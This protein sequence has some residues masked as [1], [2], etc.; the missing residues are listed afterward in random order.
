MVVEKLI[1]ECRGLQN[2]IV[3]F[4]RDFHMNPELAYEE[5]RTSSIVER[6]L[7]NLGYSVTR[8]AG[9]GVIGVIGSGGKTVALR[10]DM[11]ALPINEE[12]D[13]PYKSRV[14][15]KMHACGHD[16]HTAMLL[17]AA[18]VIAKFKDKFR[19]RVKLI[20]QPAEEGGAG[21]K[22]IVEEGHL[23]DVDAI[24]GLHVW[25]ELPSGVI[26]VRKGPF[27]ASADAFRITI[28]GRGGHAAA[29]HYAVDPIACAIDLASMYQKIITREIDPLE[30]AVISLTCIKAGTTFNVIPEE[31]VMLG[32]IRAFRE[33]VRNYIVERMKEITSKG[34]AVMR[35]EG[36]FELTKEY[37]PP[38][39]NNEELAEMAAREL[40]VLG[41][42]VEPKQSMGAEDFSFYTRKTKGLYVVLGIRNEE[43][44][45]I[46]P[47]HH[48]K[49][50]VDE[51]VLWM[52]AA[53]YSILA[54]KFLEK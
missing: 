35:C 19:G 43:K 40:K 8:A 54:Y 6:E 9:T 4:R 24:F 53:I 13:V 38:T 20:F 41:E 51:D 36:M 48:P 10:A 18:R 16:A 33:E 39:I 27:L 34:A 46:H 12:N 21:A 49:F 42:V 2:L 7:K 11:D 31:A 17:G 3:E 52:G 32:T 28:K 45:I 25:A 47:H 14:K 1:R 5:Y 29:P 44:G 22:K 23:D 37:I 50:D 30:P 26:G 15:G